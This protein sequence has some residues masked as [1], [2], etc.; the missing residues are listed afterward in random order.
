[1]GSA[2]SGCRLA[3]A[4][5]KKV[6][7]RIQTR[8]KSFQSILEQQ[9]ARDVSEADTVTL[10]KDMLSDIWGFDKY[11]DLTSEHL[12]RGTFC[13]LAVKID[14]K[15]SFLIEIKAIGL[16]LKDAHLKQAV[17]YAANQG[18]EWVILTNGISWS[19]YQVLFKKP[20]DKREVSSF[21]LMSLNPKNE[22]DLEKLFLIT[23]EG[24]T[25]NA[26]HDYRDRKEATSRYGSP[27]SC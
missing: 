16:D 10:V 23:K 17:D 4:I 15:L 11:S 5:P 8:L 13:D 20:I 27:P 6:Q 22:D 1:M 9:K 7:E 3:M 14:G 26:L 21:N 2:E 24:F 12:I 19:L 25:K 18:C